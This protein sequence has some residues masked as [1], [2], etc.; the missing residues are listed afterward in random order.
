M[1][2]ILNFNVSRNL[3][4]IKAIF[5][6]YEKTNINFILED[7]SCGK[8]TW[9]VPK[10]AVPGDIVLFM[11]AATARNNLGLATSHLPAEY[12]QQFFSFVD[13]QKALYK[14]YC[15]CILG[16]GVIS[17]APDYYE[18]ERWWMSEI[19]Q[20]CEFS[21]PINISEFRSFI[22]IS[23]TSSITRIDD[24]QWER[25]K[26]VINQRNAGVFPDACAPDAETITRE[27][28]K[29]VREKEKKPLDQLIKEARKKASMPS[30][31]KAQVK[32]YNRDPKIAASVKIRA[33]GHC[34]L[35]GQKAPFNDESGTPYLECHHI[36]W[37]SNGGM[38]SIDNCVALCPNC[39]RK[40]HILNNAGD[41][42][43][44]KAKAAE[45][46]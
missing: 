27:F 29:E 40:M 7:F 6:E 21:N 11:C 46:L 34:Q 3:E 35:C 4:D 19:A 43:F 44:L 5:D 12:G 30:V 23:R 1:V 42:D 36:K 32:V 17:S 24:K 20:L 28:E 37:L 14:K 22:N 18:V 31:I 16:Y 25:L 15:G 10:S 26:W 41:I 45:E 39:H 2:Y 9:S 33:N 38:D 13:E 8:T